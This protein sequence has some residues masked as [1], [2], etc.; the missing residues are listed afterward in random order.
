MNV[1]V[2]FAVMIFTMIAV[3]IDAKSPFGRN[4]FRGIQR[5]AQARALAKQAAAK[6]LLKNPVEMTKRFGP[7]ILVGNEF[8]ATERSRFA[9]QPN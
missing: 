8:A 1:R 7:S 5:S 2:L 9:T 6:R 4:L 3:E